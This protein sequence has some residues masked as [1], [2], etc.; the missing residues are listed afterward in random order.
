MAVTATW[1][2]VIT[3]TGAF[4]ATDAVNA[5]TNLISLAQV[6]T[7]DLAPGQNTITVPVSA[8]SIAARVTIVPPVGNTQNIVLKGAPGDTGIY[9]HVTDPTSIGLGISN[10]GV[11]LNTVFY[12][13]ATS[14]V[15]GLQLI[16]N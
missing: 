3:Y 11:G 4:T 6:Q 10:L 13:N 2:S 15:A 14:T 1:T 5:A 9:L 16:W 7:I 12:L 8:G